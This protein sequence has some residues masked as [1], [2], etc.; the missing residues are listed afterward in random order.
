MDLFDF[1]ALFG[2]SMMI[3]G[4]AL[5]WWLYRRDERPCTTL[6]SYEHEDEPVTEPFP[7]EAF[8]TEAFPTEARIRP[9]VDEQGNHIGTATYVPG[10][11]EKRLAAAQDK[12]GTML[13]PP[14]KRPSGLKR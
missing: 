14:R 7:T 8:P 3:G 10:L 6:R 11:R 12:Y 5:S 13:P 9:V 4:L 2:L 1:W